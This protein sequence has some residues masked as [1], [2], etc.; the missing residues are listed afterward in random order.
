MSGEMLEI[1]EEE[2]PFEVLLPGAGRVRAAL[3]Y[4]LRW[5]RDDPEDPWVTE[6]I[7]WKVYR[8]RPRSEKPEEVPG[9][10][11]ALV[12]REGYVRSCEE[13]GEEDHS[14]WE[15]PACVLARPGL[16]AGWRAVDIY[17]FHH[18]IPSNPL[19]APTSEPVALRRLAVDARAEAVAREIWTTNFT[20][21]MPP[22]IAVG[23]EDSSVEAD[24]RGDHE[25]TAILL[26]LVL[27]ADV[28]PWPTVWCLDLK[29]GGLDTLGSGFSALDYA[30]RHGLPGDV[31]MRAHI[32]SPAGQDGVERALNEPFPG[33][34]LALRMPE[35]RELLW[36][37]DHPRKPEQSEAEGE[38][39]AGERRQDTEEIF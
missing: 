31:T 12:I 5:Q 39:V 38:A 18:A 3:A 17:L 9:R 27:Q 14:W 2:P 6:Q 30:L 22:L 8:L 26:R 29:I 13:D 4:H 32:L 11:L 7:D 34:P 23:H 21:S 16:D 20:S 19:R 24:S 15:A 1:V 10:E 36:A 37:L 28:G 33:I 25:W 35:T